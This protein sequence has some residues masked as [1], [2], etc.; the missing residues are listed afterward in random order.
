MGRGGSKVCGSTSSP[1][2]A[3]DLTE[4]MKE[5]GCNGKFGK[6]GCESQ[7]S[8]PTIWIQP[9]FGSV[10]PSRIKCSACENSDLS[11]HS[12]QCMMKRA[13]T[14][15]DDKQNQHLVSLEAASAK[16][17]G[18]AH[19]MYTAVP[20][21]VRVDHREEDGVCRTHAVEQ[22]GPSLW[23]LNSA[24]KIAKITV[25]HIGG[26]F[27]QEL[28]GSADKHQYQGFRSNKSTLCRR[29]LSHLRVDKLEIECQ[30]GTWTLAAAHRLNYKYHSDWHTNWIDDADLSRLEE[31]GLATTLLYDPAGL[32]WLLLLQN[33]TQY[34]MCT[35]YMHAYFADL[36]Y[37]GLPEDYN[38][39][40]GT[41]FRRNCDDANKWLVETTN[42][43]A[44]GGNPNTS[45]EEP[46]KKA[47]GTRTWMADKF[48]T[49]FFA[50]A[51]GT[52]SA[53]VGA[54][55]GSESIGV[56]LTALIKDMRYAY[57]NIRAS[58]DAVAAPLAAP[59]EAAPTAPVGGLDQPYAV[60]PLERA[61]LP[62]F[63]LPLAAS[64]GAVALLILIAL[65]VARR[66][67]RPTGAPRMIRNR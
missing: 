56:P 24:G 40:T 13:S 60:A 12:N 30:D 20:F 3:A 66:T 1:I 11:L 64:L 34:A 49:P 8:V 26:R 38:I 53:P 42:N 15:G 43:F 16:L 27:A 61:N 47:R 63:V 33:G 39:C 31:K 19:G 5:I 37:G 18:S 9:C 48:P 54:A 62:S 36:S 57:F 55:L 14:G 25:K 45:L 29:A 4:C 28:G 35:G 58:D 51:N 10:D 21:G 41:R 32:V 65:I 50:D 44:C 23:H 6:K 22:D 67:Q 17:I 46:A 7:D 59:L 52:V 2:A